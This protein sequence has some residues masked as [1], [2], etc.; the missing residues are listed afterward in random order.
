MLWVELRIKPCCL[1]S[2]SHYPDQRCICSH[3]RIH[4]FLQP[5]LRIYPKKRSE[6]RLWFPIHIAW[7]ETS[8]WK[9]CCV[10]QAFSQVQKASTK[11]CFM[12]Q[13]KSIFPHT[14]IRAGLDPEELGVTAHTGF[15]EQNEAS[16]SCVRLQSI[17]RR[18][19]RALCQD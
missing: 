1:F 17:T 15:M 19:I 18:F 8:A 4:R 9:F 13:V 3:P 6:A 14:I 16:R 11:G 7:F 2:T 5:G 10:L 12:K